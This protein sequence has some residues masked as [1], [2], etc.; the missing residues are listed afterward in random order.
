MISSCMETFTQEQ[1]NNN[2]CG[3]RDYSIGNM[4]N[5]QQPCKNDDEGTLSF[6]KY[7]KMKYSSIEDQIRKNGK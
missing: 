5:K 7:D 1:D 6:Q 2:N 4:N 3:V